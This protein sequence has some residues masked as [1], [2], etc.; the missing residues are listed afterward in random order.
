M[1]EKSNTFEEI[2]SGKKILIAEDDP[3]VNIY[4]DEIFN[5]TDATV[6]MAENGKQA[7]ELFESNKDIDF[8]LMDLR[9]PLMSGFDAI[10]QILKLDS[11]AKII[12]QSAHTVQ[13]EREQCMSMGCIDYVVKPIIK[14]ELTRRIPGWLQHGNK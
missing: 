11:S 10:E 12:V 4:F 13:N 1:E 14:S 5:S 3:V 6:L 2:V 7:I 8:I 9:M